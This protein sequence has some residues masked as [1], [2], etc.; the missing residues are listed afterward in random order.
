VTVS[1]PKTLAM[2]EKLDLN[3]KLEH[4]SPHGISSVGYLYMTANPTDITRKE[5]VRGKT[6]TPGDSTA[7]AFAYW[8]SEADG[9]AI[10]RQYIEETVEFKELRTEAGQDV[11]AQQIVELAALCAGVS[12]RHGFHEE[13]DE[14]RGI[15]AVIDEPGHS[16]AGSS[17]IRELAKAN[18]TNYIGQRLLLIVSEVIEAQDDLRN[19]EQLGAVWYEDKTGQQS[20]VQVGNYQKPCGPLSELIDVLVRVFDLLG[21]FGLATDAGRLFVEKVVY[22]DSRPYKHGKK[23]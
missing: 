1:F 22:N 2:I 11:T 17:Q 10:Y 12:E 7:L 8:P 5:F 9:P 4:I 13:G 23:F 16:D 21:E 19:G 20:S 18:L 14:L 15:L 3:H 6:A